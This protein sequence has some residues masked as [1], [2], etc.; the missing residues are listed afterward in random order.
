MNWLCLG[1]HHVP[2]CSCNGDVKKTQQTHAN[3]AMQRYGR[4]LMITSLPICSTY[5]RIDRVKVFSYFIMMVNIF[6]VERAFEQFINFQPMRARSKAGEI[7]HFALPHTQ[8]ASCIIDGTDL[9]VPIFSSGRLRIGGSLF[10]IIWQEDTWTQ[11]TLNSQTFRF[12]KTNNYTIKILHRNLGMHNGNSM[13]SNNTHGGNDNIS[14]KR[15]KCLK[16]LEVFIKFIVT[17]SAS[18]KQGLGAVAVNSLATGTM[19]V[20]PVALLQQVFSPASEIETKAK[21]IDW[22]QE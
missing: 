5:L 6:S 2:Q 17:C 9:T 22:S 21:G 15:Q 12:E 10:G 7:R 18:S 13:G 14:L 1:Q 19:W 4:K 8:T 20:A 3:T 11:D 16:Y